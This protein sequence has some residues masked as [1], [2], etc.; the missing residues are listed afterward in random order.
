MTIKKSHIILLVILVLTI[1]Q[2]KIK[3]CSMYKITVAGKTMVGCNHDTWLTTPKIWFENAKG[4]NEYGA[5]F[6]GARE[7]Y[8]NRTTPQSGMNTLGLTFSRLTSY[9]PAQNNPFTNRLKIPN[10]A[11]Y[12]TDILHKCATVKDVRRYIEQYDHSFFINDVFIYIDNLGEYL[13]VEPYNLIAGNNPNYLLANFCPSITDNEQA[14]KL[15]RYRKGEDFLRTY[16]TIPSLDFCRTLSDTMSVCRKRNGDGTLLT[17][18]WDTEDKM[19][20]LYFYHAYD[21]VVQYSLKEELSKGDH[22]INV[23]EIF[24]RNSDFERLVNYKTPSNT[25]EIRILLVILAGLLSL[26]SFA[27]SISQIRKNKS[28]SVSPKSVVLIS[29]LN[30]TLI[31]Y[32]VVL[33]TNNSIFYFDVPYKHY[34]SSLISTSSYTPFLLLLIFIPFLV[35]AINRLKSDKTKLWI[36]A[37]LVSNCLVYFILVLGFGYWGLYNFWN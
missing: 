16:K 22:T 7:V 8:D 29:L 30:F 20:S 2:N 26:F 1:S 28:V 10:E 15:D 18:I 33:I 17:S 6:T 32:I 31:S 23:P 34:N 4:A 37:I 19:V 3:A 21:T 13:I 5:A 35:Y 11:D 27:L 24:P 14:R 12:L 9:Y 36:K 25:I